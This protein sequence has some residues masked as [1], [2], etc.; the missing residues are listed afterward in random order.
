[1]NRYLK[2]MVMAVAV[3]A[4]AGAAGIGTASKAEAN[5]LERPGLSVPYC[6]SNGISMYWHTENRGQA[7]APDGWRVERRHSAGPGWSNK[8]WDFMG[9]DADAL[10]IYSDKYWDW[11]DR[12]RWTGVD[13]TYRVRA[14]NSHGNEMAGRAWSRRAPV[15]C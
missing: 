5:P 1:M 15:T 7:T 8:T 9:A 14:L 13:Y 6:E 3:F 4:V 12:S 2:L 10:Q 11:T